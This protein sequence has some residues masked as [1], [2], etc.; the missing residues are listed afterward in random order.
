MAEKARAPILAI[1]NQVSGIRP[2]TIC[3]SRTDRSTHRS[4]QG[5][6]AGWL[7]QPTSVF[8][9]SRLSGA[10][11]EPV[12]DVSQLRQ[13]ILGSLLFCCF[14]L[15]FWVSVVFVVLEFKV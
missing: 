3:D 15:T 7:L 5:G 13:C 6:V 14:D 1:R 10:L 4:I 2:R 8:N 11:A 9:N 12:D